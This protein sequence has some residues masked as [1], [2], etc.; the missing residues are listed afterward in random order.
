MNDYDHCFDYSESG[1]DV[2]PDLGEA[3]RDVWR[4]I[5]N[6][7][8]WWRGGDRVAI[9]QEVRNAR[10]CQL[11]RDRK[12]ALSPF[13]ISG[14]H[15]SSGGGATN[16]PDVAIDA[17]HRLTTDPSRLTQSWLQECVAQ[18]LPLEKY[19][20]L[21]GIVVAIVSIDGF[22]RAMGFALEELPTPQAGEPSQYRPSGLEEGVAWVPMLPAANAKDDE[23][24]LYDGR[25]QTG[26]V[27]TAMS[28]VPDS[29]RILKTLSAVHYIP[30]AQVPDRHANGGRSLS[31]AQIELVAGR[32]SALSD[33]FY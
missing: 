15:V 27:V 16:L 17:V 31:R 24:D 20:E 10:N 25:K 12:E 18:G 19:V 29:V 3:H 9:A 14:S 21:L 2:R 7:G 11:C 28:L 1:Y 8:S 5:A 22:H 26:N 30:M 4:Q 23:A 33:C 32:V 13:A 6:A